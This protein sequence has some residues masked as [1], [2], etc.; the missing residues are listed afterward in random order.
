MRLL[1][2]IGGTVSAIGIFL[3]ATA[4]GDTTFLARQFPFLV[5]LNAALAA[6]LA[7]IVS[8]QLLTLARRYRAR[9]PRSVALPRA[10]RALIMHVRRSGRRLRSG[11]QCR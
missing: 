2:I 7:G 6:M 3:L 9:V 5:A 11:Q 4:S 1:L 10:A 8:Y